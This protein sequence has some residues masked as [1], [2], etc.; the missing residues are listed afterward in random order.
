MKSQ[1]IRDL[2]LQELEDRIAEL[3]E[4]MFRLRLQNLTGQLDNPLR[5]RMARKDLARCKTIRNEAARRGA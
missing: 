5:I 2:S 1:E 3:E 4:E